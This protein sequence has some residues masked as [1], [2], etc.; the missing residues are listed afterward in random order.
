MHLILT[1]SS[2]MS[3]ATQRARARTKKAAITAV[4]MMCCLWKSLH[5]QPSRNYDFAFLHRDVPGFRNRR[6]DV[7]PQ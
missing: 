2:G 3:L 5:A 1:S 4:F 6:I 7:T